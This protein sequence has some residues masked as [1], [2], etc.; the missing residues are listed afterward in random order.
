[1]AEATVTTPQTQEPEGEQ[2]QGTSR[3]SFLDPDVFLVLLVAVIID[4]LDVVLSIG[5]IVT[6]ILG[7]PLIFWMVWKTGRLE[8]AKQ[9]IQTI[10]TRG[11]ERQ[12]A[13]Q[14]ARKVATRRAL[15]KGVLYFFGGLIPGVNIFVLWTWAVISTVRGK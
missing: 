4:I 5:T 15:R 6:L 3:G 11:V 12:A 9:Q 10:R 1:M 13:K 8:D 2:Q 7:A 14:A